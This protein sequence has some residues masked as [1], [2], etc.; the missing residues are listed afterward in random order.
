MRDTNSWCLMC[1][2]LFKINVFL[3]FFSI[4]KP[5]FKFHILY[6]RLQLILQQIKSVSIPRNQK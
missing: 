3:V 1:T 6:D 2:A 5:A 4:N